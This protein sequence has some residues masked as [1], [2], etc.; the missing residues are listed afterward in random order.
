LNDDSRVR[1][2]CKKV[3]ILFYNTFI[4]KNLCLLLIITSTLFF[5]NC[6]SKKTGKII[7]IKIYDYNGDL[8]ALSGKWKE[9]GINTAFVSEALAANETFR[10]QLRKRDISVFIIFPVFQNP[11]LLAKDSSLYAI[12]AKGLK[13]KDDW[14]QFVCPSRDSY[15]KNKIAELDDIIR[16]LDPEGI[17]IDFIRQFVFWEMIYP[18]RDPSTID[19]ACYC[20]SCLAR[21]TIQKGIKIPDSCNTITQKAAWLDT[22]CSEPWN[23]FRCRLI[24]SM[25]IELAARARQIKPGVKINFHAVPWR[26][27]DF[28]KAGIK[29]AAQ[30]LKKISPFVDYVSP[31]CYSQMLK[32]DAGWISD[33]VA[34]MNRSAP[35][36]ILSSIQV[37]PEYIDN[38]FSADDFRQCLTESLKEP[39]CGVVFFSW[40]LF[41]K[42]SARMGVVT[43]ITGRNR[44]I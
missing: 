4:M 38:S 34:D 2:K 36:K 24:T 7:G 39:S 35:G 9:M 14:V 40:P 31:M 22:N 26:E 29:V 13:A 30:D 3:I 27:D 5:C 8:E 18:G 44:G 23:D 37:Y 12:T 11:E 33:V 19:R 1:E 10:Q 41:E 42:D 20:D 16:K 32:Q 43:N 25:V 15:R 6:S 17:S 21:F 28:G